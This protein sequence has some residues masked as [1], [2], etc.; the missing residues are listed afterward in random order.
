MHRFRIRAGFAALAVVLVTTG[1]K[2]TGFDDAGV[3]TTTDKARGWLVT[4]QQPGGGF[5]VSGFDGFETPDAILAMG[6]AAQQQAAWNPDQARAA[7]RAVK[8]NGRSA[9]DWADD[10]ADGAISAGQAAKLVVLVAKPLGLGVTTFDPQGDGA[11]NLLAIIDAGARPDGSYGA[12]NATLYAALAKWLVGGAVPAKTL[13]YIRGGRQASGGW[14]YANDPTASDADIDTTS[15]VVQVLVAAGVAPTDGDLVPALRFLADNQRPDGA[16]QSFG[17]D[18]PN[19]T[20]T[21]VLAVT[22]VGGDVTSSCWRDQVEPTLKGHPYS[23]PVAWLRDQQAA[24]GHLVSPNDAFPPVNTFA[25]SQGVEALR[26]GWL[27]V[28]FEVPRLCP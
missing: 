23:S 3:R 21:A 7:V 1:C 12:F 19:S 11:R 24:D 16:W 5:E 4:K 27:P 22:A 10:F 26:R 25:T 18:D 20:A 13:A 2:W 9:L 6:E 28:A 14:D 15:L 8:V 17:A